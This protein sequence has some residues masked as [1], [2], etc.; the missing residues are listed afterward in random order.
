MA[1]CGMG[2]APAIVVLKRQLCNDYDP[3]YAGQRFR[4]D[5]RRMMDTRL[6]AVGKELRY[7][8]MFVTIWKRPLES[9]QRSK[10]ARDGPAIRTWNVLSN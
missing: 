5:C 3:W 9:I 7:P 2:L 1:F 4:K 10:N 8:T 6:K